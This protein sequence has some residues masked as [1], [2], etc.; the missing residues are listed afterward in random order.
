MNRHLHKLKLESK[1]SN[2]HKHKISGY[3]QEMIGIENFHFHFFNGVSSYN[4]HT[5]YYSGITGIPIKTENGHIHKIESFLEYSQ[6]HSHDFS[7]YT[8]EDK[9]YN[10]FKPIRGVRTLCLLSNA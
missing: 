5:H 2:T 3:T 8:F 7:G 4:N 1:I 10:S 9:E 6:F